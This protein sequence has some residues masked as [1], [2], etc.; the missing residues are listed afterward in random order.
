[1]IQEMRVYN[2]LDDAAS[3]V[4]EAVHGGVPGADAA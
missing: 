3:T 1:M 4:C 2:A